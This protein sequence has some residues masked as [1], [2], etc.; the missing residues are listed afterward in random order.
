MKKK[1]VTH[2]PRFEIRQLRVGTRD[3]SANFE[4]SPH[5]SPSSWPPGGCFGPCRALQ[6]ILRHFLTFYNTNSSGYDVMD[7]IK[8]QFVLFKLHVDNEV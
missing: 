3:L 1:P 2:G 5:G 8:F 4:P 7:Q 6:L